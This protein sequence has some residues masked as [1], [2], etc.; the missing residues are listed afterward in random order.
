[1]V[2]KGES[3]NVDCQISLPGGGC[4]STPLQAIVDD[5][6]A[7]E[8]QMNFSSTYALSPG[9]LDPTNFTNY[10]DYFQGNHKYL[11]ETKPLVAMVYADF[12]IGSTAFPTAPMTQL[13]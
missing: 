7:A 3:F 2:G 8:I 11:G 13:I 4:F 12:L 9:F 5:T 6:G 10:D 1:M